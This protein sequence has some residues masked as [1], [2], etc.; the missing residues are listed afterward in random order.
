MLQ[1]QNKLTGQVVDGSLRFRVPRIVHFLIET[2]E[3]VSDAQV[4][5]IALGA[6]RLQ[7]FGVGRNSLGLFLAACQ[8]EDK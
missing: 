3:Q 8:C 7:H 6:T 2:A 1:M 4:L 5:G